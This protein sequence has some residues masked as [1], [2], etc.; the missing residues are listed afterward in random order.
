MT[1]GNKFKCSLIWIHNN[2]PIKWHY[3]I[4]TYPLF[5]PNNTTE[6]TSQYGPVYQYY[7]LVSLIGG[8]MNLANIV[9]SGVQFCL[10]NANFIKTFGTRQ[11]IIPELVNQWDPNW[12]KWEVNRV[13]KQNYGKDRS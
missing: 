12:N 2:R 9:G 1:M 13:V 5:T 3:T 6:Q 8:F 7:E 11:L 4:H 10:P